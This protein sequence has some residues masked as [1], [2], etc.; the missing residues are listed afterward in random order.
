MGAGTLDW[1][2]FRFA[3]APEQQLVLWSAEPGTPA[4]GRPAHLARSTAPRP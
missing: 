1:D 2:T 3:G 4:A